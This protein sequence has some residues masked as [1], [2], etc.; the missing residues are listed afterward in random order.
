MTADKLIHK[1]S[2]TIISE[3]IHDSDCYSCNEDIKHLNLYINNQ[4]SIKTRA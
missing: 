2:T 4:S 1:S 3:T